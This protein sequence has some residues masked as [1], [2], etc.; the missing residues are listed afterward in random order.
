MQLPNSRLRP[1]RAAAAFLCAAT[2][3]FLTSVS[4]AGDS[5]WQGSGGSAANPNNGS[6]S[7][8]ANWVSPAPNNNDANVLTFGGGTNIYTSVNDINN[9]KLGSFVLTSSASAQETI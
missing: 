8:N 1:R 6:W 3:L 9:Y 5:T 4:L 2:P 7:I